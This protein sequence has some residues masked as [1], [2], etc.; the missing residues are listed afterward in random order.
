VRR[1]LAKHGG[2]PLAVA[3]TT[4]PNI[5]PSTRVRVPRVGRTDEFE[6]FEMGLL[7]ELAVG[8]DPDA[9]PYCVQEDDRFETYQEPIE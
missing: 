5:F 6:Y 7:W 8:W 3:G 4:S 2:T 1:Y 9:R